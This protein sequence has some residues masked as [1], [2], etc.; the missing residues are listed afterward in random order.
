MFI[1]IKQLA[2]L[3]TS[4]HLGLGLVLHETCSFRTL[5]LSNHSLYSL[6]AGCPTETLSLTSSFEFQKD[7]KFISFFIHWNCSRTSIAILVIHSNT[8]KII[9]FIIPIFMGRISIFHRE[10]VAQSSSPRWWFLRSRN[11]EVCDDATHPSCE[12]PAP[13]PHG[14]EKLGDDRMHGSWLMSPL[15]ITQPLGIWSIM[16]TIRWCPIFPKWDSYQP[17]GCEKAWSYYTRNEEERGDNDVDRVSKENDEFKWKIVN[18]SDRACHG[19]PCGHM[20]HVHYLDGPW[21]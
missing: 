21:S 15:N 13:W 7:H 9:S 16:A 12:T 5:T 17:L 1:R 19:K 3:S 18:D 20:Q 11:L 6:Y 8:I 2:E 10:N 14:A 4:D